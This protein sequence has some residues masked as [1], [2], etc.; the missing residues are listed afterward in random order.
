MIRW[1]SDVIEDHLDHRVIIVS[2]AL[3]DYAGRHDP[4]GAPLYDEGAG[5]DYGIGP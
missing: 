2:H 3:T 5:Y 1:A 4:L